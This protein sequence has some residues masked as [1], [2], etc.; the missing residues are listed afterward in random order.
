M[1]L[2]VGHAGQ[3]GLCAGGGLALRGQVTLRVGQPLGQGVEPFGGNL[4][5]RLVP[6]VGPGQ[7]GQRGL[8]LGELVVSRQLLQPRRLLGGLGAVQLSPRRVDVGVQVG[9]LFGA[10]QRPP[11]G[12]LVLLDLQ[13]EPQPL[14]IGAEGEELLRLLTL[15]RQRLDLHLQPGGKILEPLQVGPRFVQPAH[16]LVAPR[17]V[18]LD[19][20]DLFEQSPPVGRL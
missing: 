5:L 6:L 19:P 10:A 11:L 7:L 20:G 2:L 1:C 12:E 9:Q 15:H 8:R 13:A 3:L 18:A 4:T 17:A 16:G 14:R